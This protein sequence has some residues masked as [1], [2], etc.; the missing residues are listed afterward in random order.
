MSGTVELLTSTDSGKTY[1]PYN[2]RRI[3]NLPLSEGDLPS[4]LPQRAS[5][6]PLAWQVFKNS[7]S[8]E[9]VEALRTVLLSK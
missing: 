8:F 3:K 7:A 1:I 9:Q 6:W 4:I 2:P 5:A